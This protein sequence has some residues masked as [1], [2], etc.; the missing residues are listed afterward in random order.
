MSAAYDSYDYP[1]Y[2]TGRE[3]EHKSELV[4]IKAFL[5]KISHIKK[6]LEV[7]AGYGRLT[8]SYLYRAPK[9]ILTDPSARL[10][11]IA[12]ENLKNKKIRFVQALLENLPQKIKPHSVDVII[13]VRVLHHVENLEK[14]FSIIRKLCKKNG[15]FILEFAN[16]RHLKAVIQEAAHGN[17]TFLVDVFT[18]DVATRKR[19]KKSYLPFKNFHPDLILYTL[20]R[21]GFTVVDVRSVSNIRSPFLKK[22]L[23]LEFLLF[24]ENILQKPLAKFFV[25]PSIF[26]LAKKVR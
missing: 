4:A 8:Q 13:M 7:G 17:F 2:W 18:K 25:G 19:K 26:I 10:L 11:K 12:R 24:L 15:Y 14:S 6:I 1:G 3:Y 5:E 16:K 9:I 23:P 22:F 20:K 21:F